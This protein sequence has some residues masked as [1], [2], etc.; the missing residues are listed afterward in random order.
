M[1]DA[2]VKAR[3]YGVYTVQINKLI[4]N[5][6]TVHTT[7][8]GNKKDPNLLLFRARNDKIFLIVNI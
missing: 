4:E 3:L 2:V 1:A 8:C 7:G 5:N 6:D